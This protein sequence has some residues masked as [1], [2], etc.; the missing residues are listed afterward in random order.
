[1]A[2]PEHVYKGFRDKIM[3]EY[4]VSEFL[5]MPVYFCRKC[6][7]QVDANVVKA[8]KNLNPETPIMTTCCKEEVI[9]GKLIFEE[10]D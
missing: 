7:T 6:G 2:N 1:M 8:F 10:D 4:D 3:K 9:E 5:T